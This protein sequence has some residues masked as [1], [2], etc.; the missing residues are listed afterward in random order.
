[1]DD[2]PMML[3]MLE[4]VVHGPDMRVTTAS[5]PVQAFIQARDLKPALIISDIQMGRFGTGDQ[6]LRELR[7]DSRLTG[8]PFIFM[9][10]MELDKAKEIIPQNDPTVRLLQKPIDWKLLE[11][12]VMELTGLKFSS[13]GES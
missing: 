3:Q 10:G 6:T 7:K 11:T 8:I 13:E 5:D 12:Y 2:D 9:T 1:V 4:E